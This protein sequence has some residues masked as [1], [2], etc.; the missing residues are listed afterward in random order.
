MPAV[1]TS[2]NEVNLAII[3]LDQNS[4]P[5]TGLTAGSGAGGFTNAD[6]TVTLLRS[7][8]TTYIA[9]TET[10][11]L[12]EASS[13]GTYGF[14][15][16]P[17]NTGTYLLHVKELN[18]STNGYTHDRYVEVVTSGSQFIPSL[19]EAFCSEAD[20]ERWLQQSL[21]A[22]TRPSSTEAAAFA[23]T[24]S[25]MLQSL[26]ASKGYTVTPSTVTSGSRL[27]DL[28]RE[29]NALGAA[30]DCVAVQAF[31]TAPSKTDKASWLESLWDRYFGRPAEPGKAGI[32][33]LIEMEI[34]GNLASLATDHILSGDTT[35]ADSSSTPPTDIGISVSMSDLY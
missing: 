30:C 8:G 11:T 29:A 6:F 31:G 27:Q 12:A 10:V 19:A 24:R 15:F 4:D 5:L 2:G 25:A 17:A 21:T 7:S 35:A 23:E 13:A 22:T 32:V 3:V 9:A 26:C 14:R 20:I 16:T 33:G 28:L 1:Y 18:A 34:R